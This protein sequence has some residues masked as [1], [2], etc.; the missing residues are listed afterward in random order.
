MHRMMDQQEGVKHG[1]RMEIVD[2]TDTRYELYCEDE[3]RQYYR[4]VSHKLTYNHRWNRAQ[5]STFDRGY[6]VFVSRPERVNES[7]L[8][9][10]PL[11]TPYKCIRY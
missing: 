6:I 10:S 3:D 9:R 4:I 8:G 1:E 7:T 5:G 11:P 2:R